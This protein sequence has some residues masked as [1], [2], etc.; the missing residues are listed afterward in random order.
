[1]DL[2]LHSTTCLH[3]KQGNLGN[4]INFLSTIFAT[5]SNESTNYMQQLITSLLL[6]VQIQLNMIRASLCPLS[7]DYQLQ[8]PLVLPLECGGSNAVGRSRAGRPDHGQQH[9][10]HHIPTVKPEAATEVVAPDD[11]H[12]DVRNMLSCI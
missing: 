5:H 11:G 2:H 6:A 8:Q 12:E 1:M 10:Y 4:F 3:G 7:G 9:F